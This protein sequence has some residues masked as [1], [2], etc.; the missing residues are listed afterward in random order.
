M[1][2]PDHKTRIVATIGPASQDPT[3]LR[4]MLE[5]GLDVARLNF[6]HGSEAYHAGLIRTLRAV[7][8]E[9]G[10]R[11]AIM[12]DLPGPK[13]RI[14][15]LA[16]EPV[17]LLRDATITLTTR[18]LVG[19]PGLVS[20]SFAAL[21]AAVRP[22]DRL[23]INDGF[24]LL[25]VQE[26]RGED[27]VCSVRVGGEL[28]SRKGLN[29][30]GI[31]LG[32][33]AFTGQDHKWLRFAAEMGVDA[34][35][36]SFV[37]CPADIEAVRAAA[38]ALDYH[39]FIIA[40]IERRDALDQLDAILAASDGIMVARGDLGVEI[41]IE[42]IALVQKRIVAQANRAGKPVITATHLLRGPG[43]QGRC[44]PRR[45]G[46]LCAPLA[47][48][49]GHPGGPGPARPGPLGPEPLRQPPHGDRRARPPA[50]HL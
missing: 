17:E 19:H 38:K 22:G 16:E 8:A 27:V 46:R 15:D 26:V 28:R 44:G 13:M 7:A 23:F 45:L 32:I 30:P 20:V 12:G 43:D 47:G 39:P 1:N 42:Q 37:A 31:D 34:V 25:K 21:P 35:S 5:A 24:I 2:F 14:G 29:L 10:R 33:S 40:K 9:T 6:S 48:R 4:A 18:D 3:T 50:P 41:P 36:Q 11:V 49:P